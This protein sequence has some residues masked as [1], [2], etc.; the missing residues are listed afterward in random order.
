MGQVNGADIQI[1]NGNYSRLHN[2]IMEA[3]SQVRLT[4]TEHAIVMFL[5]RQ[6]YGYQR[7]QARISYNEFERYLAYS[8]RGIIKAL[9][10]LVEKKIINQVRETGRDAY[11]WSFNK[12]HEQWLIDGQKV[13]PK[14]NIPKL[15]GKSSPPKVEPECNHEPQF[16]HEPQLHTKV[17]PE[18]N[19]KV[20]PECNPLKDNIKEKKENN[21]GGSCELPT[22]DIKEVTRFYETNIGTLTEYTKQELEALVADYGGTAIVV[23][24]MRVAVQANKKSLRYTHGVLRNW[25][26]DGR[27]G[28]K[29]PALLPQA[30]LPSTLPASVFDV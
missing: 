3:V 13:S 7:T 14:F 29:A 22:E 24:A 12:Y 15:G 4:G 19:L 1:E 25:H 5:L 16:N 17:E 27:N 21:D 6:T 20:E 9:D 30:T 2:H 26:A 10:M 8:K 18:C 23:D 11:W 28:N